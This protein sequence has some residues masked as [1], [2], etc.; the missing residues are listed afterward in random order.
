MN[1]RDRMNK[2]FED[3]RQERTVINGFLNR[4]GSDEAREAIQI[5][6]ELADMIIYHANA[7]DNAK[8]MSETWEM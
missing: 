3:K 6:D 1:I 7:R 2:E 5:I 8:L 4:V